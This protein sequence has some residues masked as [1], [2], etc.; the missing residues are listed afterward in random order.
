MAGASFALV[1][2]WSARSPTG[3]Q[4]ARS[5]LPSNAAVLET[6]AVIADLDDVAVVGEPVAHGGG[7]M[8]SQSTLGHLRNARLV[9][10]ITEVHS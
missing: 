4:P 2:V 9:V 7:R 1:T 3:R 10:M 5:V 8:Q 6:P